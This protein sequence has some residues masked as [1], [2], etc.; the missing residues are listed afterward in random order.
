[1]THWQFTHLIISIVMIGAGIVAEMIIMIIVLGQ[2]LAEL[3]KRK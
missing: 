3:R 1:M 2:I